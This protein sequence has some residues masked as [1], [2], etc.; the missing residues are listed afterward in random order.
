MFGRKNKENTLKQESQELQDSIATSVENSEGGISNIQKSKLITLDKKVEAILFYKGEEVSLDFLVKI[1]AEKKPNIL[2]A[3]G[4]LKNRLSDSSIEVLEDGEKF[5]L[6]VKKEYAE[7]ISQ[8]RGEENLGELSSSA[9]ETLSI[10]LYKGPISK[11]EIDQIRGVNASYILRNLLIRGLV[12]RKS[13]AGKTV[14]TETFDLMR[15]LG[16]SDKKN[17]PGYEKVIEK[18]NQI[19]VSEEEVFRKTEEQGEGVKQNDNNKIN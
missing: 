16:V 18:L 2:E 3:I 11:S 14:Y 5:L 9:L 12:E 4:L 13:E 7:F 8:L 19:D 17:L 10:I 15:Y 6:V 1:L